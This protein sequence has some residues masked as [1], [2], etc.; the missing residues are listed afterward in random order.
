MD[1]KTAFLNGELN[2]VVYVSQPEGFVDPDLPT[3]VYRLKKSLYGLKQA[4]RAWYDKLSRFFM[5]TGFSEGVVDPT[6]F[7]RKTG[8]HILLV[9]IYVDDIIFAS[10][11]PN[12]PMYLS[13]S[14]PDN[15]LLVCYVCPR[16]SK[17]PLTSYKRKDSKLKDISTGSPPNTETKAVIDPVVHIVLWYLDSGCSRHMTDDRS[18]L[19]NYV[20]KFIGTV[21]FGNDQFAA[22]VGYGDYKFGDTIITRRTASIR[23]SDTSVLEDLKALNWKTCQGGP[24]FKL[25]KGTRSNYDELEYDFEECFKALS[26]K[27][28]WE[29]PEGSDYPFDLT[30]PLPLVMSGNCQK[31][32]KTW[33]HI[34]GFLLKLPMI[35]MRYGVSHIGENNVEVMRKHG[36]GYLKE[37][38]V[39]KADNDLYRFKEGDFLRL[40]NN[41]IEDMLLLVVKNR[42]TNLS[43]NDVFDFAIALRMFTKSLVIQKRVKDLHLGV[44]SYQKKINV[45]KPETTR[46]GL[47]KRD[48]FT[49]YQDPQGFIYVDNQ[50]RNRLMRSDELYKFSDGILTRLLSSL[51]DITNNINVDYLPKRRWS[52]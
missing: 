45:T 36:Y 22:I 6:L 40:R 9:Q 30:N 39:R 12:S 16:F 38:I 48:P 4:P 19:I 26:E 50:E 32:L 17:K 28:D 1:V 15:V 23:E 21:R 14:R 52:T 51:E 31:A 34:Y 11:N 10:T 35:N 8:K 41:D 18:K 3:H 43:G 27:L 33:F 29:N 47:R 46:P 25:L 49:P 2:E 42:L 37:I 20:E 5:S 44:K 13:A 7:T 24:A